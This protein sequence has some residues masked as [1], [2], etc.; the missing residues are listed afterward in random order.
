MLGMVEGDG[1]PPEPN[2]VAG[3]RPDPSR[4]AAR[5]M[6]GSREKARGLGLGLTGDR[7][8]CSPPSA[9]NSLL[10]ASWGVELGGALPPPPPPPPQAEKPTTTSTASQRVA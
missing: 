7:M 9:T 8:A 4:V 5:V 3:P 6:I 1:V 2:P 10:A